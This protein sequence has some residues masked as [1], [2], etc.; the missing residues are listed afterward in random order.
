MPVFHLEATVVTG[1][2]INIENQRQQNLLFDE[3]N[4]IA[5]P[6]FDIHVN[7]VFA[8]LYKPG[9]LSDGQMKKFVQNTL[10]RLH[11]D[12]ELNKQRRDFL[13]EYSLRPWFENKWEIRFAFS[14]NHRKGY[15]TQDIRRY[16]LDHFPL[17]GLPMNRVSKRY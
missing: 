14:P 7:V 8:P 4:T 15:S 13:Y 6:Y 16:K 2:E 12:E 9:R 1:E 3:L 5:S 17:S 11:Y 10:A